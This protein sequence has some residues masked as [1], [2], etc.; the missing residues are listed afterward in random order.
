MKKVLT[1]LGKSV[2]VPLRLKAVVSSTD[3]TIEKKIFGS[4][5]TALTISIEEVQDIMKIVKY[6]EEMDLLI[7]GVSET[8]KNVAKE[9]KF[10]FLD[11]LLGRLVAGFM[12][13]M[14]A[15]KLK[16]LGKE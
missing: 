12:G 13:N 16:Y 3:A 9:Q 11:M 2:L 4:G 15:G 1:H 7:K 6:L 5:T 8:I 14:L 10:R